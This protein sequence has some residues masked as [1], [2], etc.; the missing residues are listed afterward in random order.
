MH[1]KV[2]ERIWRRDGEVWIID[3]SWAVWAPFLA[4]S[5]PL[6]AYVTKF[7]QSLSSPKLPDAPQIILPIS[8]NRLWRIWRSEYLSHFPASPRFFTAFSGFSKYIEK[9]GPNQY[10]WGV[11]Q[12]ADSPAAQRYPHH[13]GEAQLLEALLL[14]HGDDASRHL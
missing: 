11:S 9:Y 7:S 4:F 13:R 1:G 12:Q 5:L 14:P 6:S 8:P 10:K 3:Q 2:G